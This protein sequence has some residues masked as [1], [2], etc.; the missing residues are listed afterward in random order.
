M[1]IHSAQKIALAAVPVDAVRDRCPERTG[2]TIRSVCCRR[3]WYQTL[4]RS[5]FC[6][7]GIQLLCRIPHAA[8]LSQQVLPKRAVSGPA[9]AKN[10]ESLPRGEQVSLPDVR[11]LNYKPGCCDVGREAQD[12]PV[13]SFWQ[14]G[15]PSDV[16]EQEVFDRRRIGRDS[17]C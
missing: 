15:Q 13:R 7:G 14:G 11:D 5:A 8:G 10:G 16:A 12:S 9:A 6:G 3:G 4:P 2:P 1:N 17:Q